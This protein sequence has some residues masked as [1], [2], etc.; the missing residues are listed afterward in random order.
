MITT[1][2]CMKNKKKERIPLNKN[3]TFLNSLVYKNPTFIEDKIGLFSSVTILKALQ[4]K[5]SYN[6]AWQSWSYWHSSAIIVV[7]VDQ[8]SDSDLNSERVRK[9]LLLFSLSLALSFERDLLALLLPC[10]SD[11]RSV[12]PACEF[13][14]YVFWALS[15]AVFLLAPLLSSLGFFWR[16]F[17]TAHRTLE[18]E[19]FCY[20][21]SVVSSDT[22][23]SFLP[24]FSLLRCLWFLIFFFFYLT[25]ICLLRCLSKKCRRF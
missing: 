18:E 3:T 5:R 16:H 25:P 17:V 23:F 10:V 9:R 4:Q 2:K 20:I 13:V 24:S 8:D 22:L 21:S 6:G 7:V 12:L 15:T 1:E 19:E 14:F 11:N